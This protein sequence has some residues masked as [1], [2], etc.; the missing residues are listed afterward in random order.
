MHF[1]KRTIV[2]FREKRFWKILYFWE[3][4]ILYF[5]KKIVFCGKLCVFEKFS[6]FEENLVFLDPGFE[7]TKV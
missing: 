4:L 3:N 5:T 6:Y 2:F 1:R 7:R